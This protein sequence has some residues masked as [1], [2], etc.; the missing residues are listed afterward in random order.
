MYIINNKYGTV[1]ATCKDCKC[2]YYVSFCIQIFSR[3]VESVI[4]TN[5]QKLFAEILIEM[6]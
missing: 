5:L 2:E 1:F 6:Q 4:R 3:H